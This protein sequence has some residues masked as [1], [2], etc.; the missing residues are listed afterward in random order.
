MNKTIRRIIF[1]TDV[2]ANHVEVLDTYH[3]RFLIEFQYRDAK[4]AT[5]LTHSQARSLNKL[6]SHFNFALT[7]VNVAK[8]A[9]WKRSKQKD[10]PFSITQTKILMH[11]Q[12]MIELFIRKFGI[13]PNSKK[14]HNIV[15]ELILYGTKAA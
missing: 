4:Q 6:H 2:E 7:A 5:G 10:A 11:N 14:N 9:H 15:K 13:N 3:A 1:S 12:L 8:I